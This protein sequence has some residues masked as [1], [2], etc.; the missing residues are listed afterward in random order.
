[1]QSTSEVCSPAYTP[2]DSDLAKVL[3]VPRRSVL[4]SLGA[5]AS[6]LAV[7]NAVVL[8]FHF[9]WRVVDDTTNLNSCRS[10][11]CDL[12]TILSSRSDI[13]RRKIPSVE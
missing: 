3:K 1:M 9:E 13:H 5:R 7:F 2:G 12:S 11:D 6:P 4:G 10:M 8:S